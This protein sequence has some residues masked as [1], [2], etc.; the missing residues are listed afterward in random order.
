MDCSLIAQQCV[1][2]N[3]DGHQ[4][5]DAPDG[6]MGERRHA[7]AEHFEADSEMER[8]EH[9]GK[10]GYQKAEEVAGNP[11]GYGVVVNLRQKE[12]ADDRHVEEDGY[13]QHDERQAVE[14]QEC[15]NGKQKQDDAKLTEEVE[16][17]ELPANP[18]RVGRNPEQSD[19]DR[20]GPGK[21]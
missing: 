1:E 6:P 2:G 3:S 9:S 19:D 13:K 15:G 11:P 4:Q 12:T 18:R 7:I 8:H 16:R 20:N 14:G 10:N 21:Y 17:Q 5:E